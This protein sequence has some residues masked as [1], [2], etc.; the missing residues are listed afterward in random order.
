MNIPH[1]FAVSL[2]ISTTSRPA[3]NPT[4]STVTFAKRLFFS[5]AQRPENE[6]MTHLHRVLSLTM[7]GVI[8]PI[9]HFSSE[10]AVTSAVPDYVPKHH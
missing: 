9:V 10:A 1:A 4:Q 6:T 8:P 5:V 7:R 2:L 3:L